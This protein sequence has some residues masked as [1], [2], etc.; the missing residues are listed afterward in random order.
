MQKNEVI[1]LLKYL[2]DCYPNKF[3]F[4]KE[5]KT[6]TQMIIEVWYD[7]L[8]YYDYK[9][10]AKAAKKLVIIDGK[11]PP[12]VGQIVREVKKIKEAEEDRITAG[13][14]WKMVLD[15]VRKY[16][17]YKPIKAMNSLPPKVQQAVEHFGGYN[18]ICHSRENDPFVRTQFFRLYNEVN[19]HK[20]DLDYLPE[21]FRR[22]ILLLSDDINLDNT[23]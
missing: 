7:F 10:S 18:V 5:N 8:Q 11:W 13:M 21:E 19:R 2:S 4:P 22:E 23:N 9:I 1:K 6:E 15:A 20:R 16:G 17:Y 14:A 12:S 3:K